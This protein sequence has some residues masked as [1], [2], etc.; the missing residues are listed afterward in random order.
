MQN[1]PAY[2]WNELAF[3]VL[4]KVSNWVS[5]S[6]QPQSITS[7]R[8]N[9]LIS[10]CTF[11]N[12]FHNFPKLKVPNQ[13]IQKYKTFIH[14]YMNFCCFS[15]CKHVCGG[16]E[17]G[18]FFLL[19]WL[20]LI[21]LFSP[22]P[23]LIRLFLFES[24]M[25]RSMTFGHKQK[26][27]QDTLVWK[28]FGHKQKFKQDTRLSMTFGHKQK[29]KQDTHECHNTWGKKNVWQTATPFLT[30]RCMMYLGFSSIHQSCCNVVR[31]VTANIS[32]NPWN[33]WLIISLIMCLLF[34]CMYSLL[35]IMFILVNRLH[36]SLL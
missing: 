11:Q 29:F 15:L 14:S 10:K 3:S 16:G 17:E 35:W 18:G 6:C 20:L 2:A 26:F 28:T 33:V 1:R 21:A 24:E 7:G 8:S 13:S 34:F 22:L 12:S 30:S 19:L 9:S 4:V 32:L 27:K 5:A 23:S 25:A 31:K 36:T